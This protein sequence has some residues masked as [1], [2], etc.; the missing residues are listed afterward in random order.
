MTEE[1][2][3]KVD[4]YIL[5]SVQSS[6]EEVK[7]TGERIKSELEKMA[8]DFEISVGD[9]RDAQ[10]SVRAKMPELKYNK[11]SYYAYISGKTSKETYEKVFGAK[12]E[13]GIDPDYRPDTK[14]W[15]VQERAKKPDQFLEKI[16]AIEL[17]YW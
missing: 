9:V 16:D 7:K 17:D 5:L 13:Y 6:P 1:K 3:P 2:L 15:I 4:F 14:I 10:G 8:D 11:N 12:L